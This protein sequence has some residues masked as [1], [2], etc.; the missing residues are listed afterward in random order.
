MCAKNGDVTQHMYATWDAIRWD[1]EAAPKKKV[2]I[3]DFKN[4]VDSVF[5]MMI[6]HALKTMNLAFKMMHFV[7]QK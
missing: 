1:T 3:L 6:L 4:M 2:R 5:K 7:Y